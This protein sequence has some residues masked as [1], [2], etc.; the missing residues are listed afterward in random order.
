[1]CHVLVTTC[2]MASKRAPSEVEL[3]ECWWTSCSLTCAISTLESDFSSFAVVLQQW[4][5]AVTRISTGVADW[6]VGGLEKWA[7]NRIFPS[8]EGFVSTIM[9]KI[10]KFLQFIIENRKNHCSETIAVKMEET[11]HRKTKMQT[12]KNLAENSSEQQ[13]FFH[14]PPARLDTVVL[15]TKAPAKAKRVAFS[16]VLWPENVAHQFIPSRG[17]P[18]QVAKQAVGWMDHDGTWKSWLGCRCWKS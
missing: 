11:N 14:P 9:V 18:T 16:P 2:F 12:E 4:Y 6:G 1:M 8:H 17:S 5:A 15:P 13:F 3:A 7:D 10:R